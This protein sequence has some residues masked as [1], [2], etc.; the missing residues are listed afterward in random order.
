MIDIC[1]FSFEKL[2]T[3][4]AWSWQ[5]IGSDKSGTVNTEAADQDKGFG[6]Q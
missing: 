4:K 6:V 3:I 5:M 1:Q 2:T